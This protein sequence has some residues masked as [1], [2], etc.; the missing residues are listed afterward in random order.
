MKTLIK[1]AA[2][3]LCS[4]TMSCDQDN[5][6]SSETL[7]EGSTTTKI[8]AK[9]NEINL[10]INNRGYLMFANENEVALYIDYITNRSLGEVLDIFAQ[11][12]F[13][14]L[15]ST[16]YDKAV[17][18]E[19][20]TFNNAGLVQIGN[21]VFKISNDGSYLLSIQENYMSDDAIFQRMAAG[22][23]QPQLMNRFSL[24][25]DRGNADFNIL[26]TAEGNP[27]GIDEERSTSS[28]TG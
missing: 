14:P 24:F 21:S 23:F 5:I 12:N 3:L 28:C 20:F 19:Q 10:K 7:S 16:D 22:D 6:T 11:Y 2:V 15:N 17:N 8:A 27:S 9:N 25:K 18:P 13:Q 1:L 26:D 4:L